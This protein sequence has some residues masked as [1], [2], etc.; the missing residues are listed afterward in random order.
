MQV[1]R[2]RSSNRESTKVFL[3][4]VHIAWIIKG[5]QRS[6]TGNCGAEIF[7]DVSID[8]LFSVFIPYRK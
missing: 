7:S 1:K 4:M 8:L 3:L 6:L 5:I 2:D